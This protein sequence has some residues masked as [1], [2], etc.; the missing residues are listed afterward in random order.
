MQK[1]NNT[2]P[3]PGM[4]KGES[5]EA[6]KSHL[7]SREAKGRKVSKDSLGHFNRLGYFGIYQFGIQALEDIGYLHEGSYARYDKSGKGSQK[8]FLRDR[9]NWTGT[10]NISWFTNKANQD[11]AILAFTRKNYKTIKDALTSKG[12]N[13]LGEI[14]GYLTAAHLGGA[15][16][17]KKYISAGKSSFKDANN[18]S[19]KQYKDSFTDY[20]R[21]NVGKDTK[22]DAIIRGEAPMEPPTYG[23]IRLNRAIDM[24][25][26]KVETRDSSF[27]EEENG[28]MREA[29]E[30]IMTKQADFNDKGDII[31]K[32]VS[33]AYD[34]TDIEEL[35]D[36]L[37][38][39]I[40]EEPSEMVPSDSLNIEQSTNKLAYGGLL[41]PNG[42]ITNFTRP[43]DIKAQQNTK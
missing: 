28:R 35:R 42:R 17:A 30:M 20:Y 29:L 39:D 2:T 3:V 9:S 36:T 11:D 22:R 33:A 18:T 40:I 16:T 37:T 7:I 1:Q 8:E 34:N 26:K 6:Y 4:F 23:S 38:P 43:E 12:V 5:W 13:T 25:L 21:K 19:L 41:Q 10:R 32:T 31:D 15:G 27:G 14:Y 24:I